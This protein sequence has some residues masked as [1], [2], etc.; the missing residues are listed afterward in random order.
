MPIQQ[1]KRK[2]RITKTKRK[3]KVNTGDWRKSIRAMKHTERATCPLDEKGSVKATIAKLKELM[4][5]DGADWKLV[6]ENDKK[7]GTF[8]VER[9]Q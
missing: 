1:N 9:V 5:K 3:R 4:W 2:K 7:K 6:G 8:V